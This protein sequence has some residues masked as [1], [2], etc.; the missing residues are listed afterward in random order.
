MKKE[1]IHEYNVL[2]MKSPSKK[3]IDKNIFFN[4]WD[5]AIID[6]DVVEYNPTLRRMRYEDH[7]SYNIG[8]LLYENYTTA[9]LQHGSFHNICE[10]FKEFLDDKI[11]KYRNNN[12]LCSSNKIL[13]ENLRALWKAQQESREEDVVENWCEW[14]PSTEYYC[15][16][17]SPLKASLSTFFILLITLLLVFFIYYNHPK[18]KKFIY[19]KSYRDYVIRYFMQHLLPYR[20][21]ED[22][23][24]DFNTIRLMYTICI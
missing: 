11:N 17:I 7:E 4:Q 14:E 23:S 6:K 18:I 1:R 24:L 5:K 2:K 8:C 9:K 21:R 19:D 10:Y 13:N 12:R 22:F 15:Y 20:N 3:N 16:A